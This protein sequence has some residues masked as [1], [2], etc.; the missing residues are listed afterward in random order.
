MLTLNFVSRRWHIKNC[1]LAVWECSIYS[2]NLNSV[3]KRTSPLSRFRLLCDWTWVMCPSE[4]PAHRI[5]PTA[6][7]GVR[8]RS[9]WTVQIS[10]PVVLA[11]L[12]GESHLSSVWCRHQRQRGTSNSEA[13]EAFN[14]WN[15]ARW[16]IIAPQGFA[17]Y[18]DTREHSSF[19]IIDRA[20]M[21]MTVPFNSTEITDN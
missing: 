21:A 18:F 14:G 6:R 17:K 12:T 11:P 10:L 7:D 20:V 15:F 9:S 8:A 5:V 2:M 4:I 16:V 3:W 13:T 1:R 19:S